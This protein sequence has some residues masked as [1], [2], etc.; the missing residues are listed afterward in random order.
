M[1]SNADDALAVAL[2]AGFYLIW[3]VICAAIA[4]DH[5]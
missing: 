1:L 2:T 5:A 4:S 3:G